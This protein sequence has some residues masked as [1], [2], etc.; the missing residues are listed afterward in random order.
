VSALTPAQQMALNW[1]AERGGEGVI[2]RYGRI[3]AKGDVYR[4][5]HGATWLRLVALR[6]LIG[7]GH[8]G[9]LALS[10]DG[11]GLAQRR[12]DPTNQVPHAR[13]NIPLMVD[14]NPEDF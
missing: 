3:I 13:S 9:R 14:D 4:G 2:D 12:P 5:E 1:L 6:F 11:K 8:A 7:T 10:D